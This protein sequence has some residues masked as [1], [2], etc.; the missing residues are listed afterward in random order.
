MQT[1]RRAPL[2]ALVKDA[3]APLKALNVELAAVEEERAEPLS[4]PAGELVQAAS[5]ARVGWE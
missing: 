5:C 1:T 3:K 4:L 2:N